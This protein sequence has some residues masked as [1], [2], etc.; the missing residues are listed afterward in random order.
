VPN[1][2]LAQAIVT[3]YNLPEKRMS[4]SFVVT[5]GYECDSDAI[6]QILADVLRKAAGEIPGM[7]E[8]P[9]PSVAFEPGFAES[10]MGFTANFQVAEFASQSPVRNELRRR[11][12]RRFRAEGIGVAYPARTVYLRGA[13]GKHALP[14]EGQGADVA[15]KKDI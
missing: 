3:N 9:A 13:D 2:K 5:V 7:L 15:G 11:V 8:E 4:G 6:E 10:G 1:A 12:L 14:G